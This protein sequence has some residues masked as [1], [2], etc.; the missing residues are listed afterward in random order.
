MC[1]IV[2]KE[3]SFETAEKPITCFVIRSIQHTDK[4]RKIFSPYWGSVWRIGKL[5]EDHVKVRR[6]ASFNFDNKDVIESGVFHSFV[7]E[8]D[9]IRLAKNLSNIRFATRFGIFKAEIPADSCFI[10]GIHLTLGIGYGSKKLKLVKELGFF[11][12]GEPI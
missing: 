6:F 10:T 3:K 2:S 9:A 8:D 4:G 1:L 7:D 12:A 11:K 5:R